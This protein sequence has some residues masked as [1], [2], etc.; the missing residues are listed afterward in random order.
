M[1]KNFFNDKTNLFL[2]IS[3]LGIAI[4]VIWL[5]T[6]NSSK[7]AQWLVMEHN[8]GWQF[9]DFYRHIVYSSDL[10]NVYFHTADACFPPLAYLFYNSLFQMNPKNYNVTLNSWQ[11]CMNYQFN[12]LIFLMVEIINVILFYAILKKYFKNISDKKFLLLMLAILFSAPFLA[13]AL[14]RG[15]AAFA[16]LTLVLYSLY[17]KDSENKLYRQ[18]SLII[19]AIATGFKLY[20]AIFILLWLKDKRIKDIFMF[21]IYCFIFVLLPFAFTGGF[22]GFNKYCKNLFSLTKYHTIRWTSIE[23]Y[24]YSLCHTLHIRYV[25]LIVQFIRFLFL[26]FGCL[27]AIFSKEKWKACIP[28]ST[29]MGVFVTNSYRYVSIY[30]LI[31]LVYL[32]SSKIKAKNLDYVYVIIFALLFTI[33]VWVINLEVDFAIF[34]LIYLLNI[35]L[36]IETIYYG[37][38]NRNKDIKELFK[39]QS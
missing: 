24:L 13:G 32:L 17:L 16:V 3:L 8:Y 30:L 35:I 1:N 33:P 34:T 11:E 31:P 36:I 27:Y 38:K 14:E 5:I 22:A 39:L 4:F 23:L 9:S 26:I 37:F 25:S 12:G 10:S 20:P 15:N 28:L 2:T 21:S 29:L 7:P 6:S 19:L 18:F